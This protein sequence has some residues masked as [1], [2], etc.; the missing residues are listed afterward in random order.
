MQSHD[1]VPGVS[2]WKIDPT[3][4][5]FELCSNQVT[6]SGSDPR[7]TYTQKPQAEEVFFIADGKMYINRAAIDESLIV[8]FNVRDDWSVRM[9][10]TAGGQK[11]AAG[12]GVG[13]DQF[14]VDAARF[15]VTSDGMTD[16]ERAIKSGDA[17][18]ILGM[19]AS[20][21]SETKLAPGLKSLITDQ[22]REMLRAELKPGGMLYRS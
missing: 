6:V 13:V 21:I 9:E 20:K 7:A 14:V 12:I 10:T 19:L 15:G 16:M 22:A 2:G 8:N 11:Y 17:C 4:G 18:E 1:Y 3:T 5:A